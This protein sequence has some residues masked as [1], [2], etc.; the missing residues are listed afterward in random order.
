M[1]LAIGGKLESGKDTV[2]DYLVEK[3]K[4]V[5][6]A[7]ADN[8]KEM[9][10]HI[11]GL[12]EADCYTTEGKL[13]KFDEPI[14][15]DRI[16]NKYI[17]KEVIRWLS[18]VNNWKVTE[19]NVAKLIKLFEDVEGRKLYT[20][21]EVLQFFGTEVLRDC[22]DSDI[23]AKIVLKE[24]ARDEIEKA[25]IADARFENERKMVTAKGGKTVLIDC[26]Q[27]REQKSEH[28]SETG[29]GTKE[30]YDYYIVNDKEDGL[31]NLFMTVNQ[32]M[33]SLNE[34]TNRN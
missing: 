3:F 14:V 31:D 16:G 7:F 32:L 28:R 34:D 24:I 22:I 18:D 33:E 21:R 20:T 6:L 5:K 15:L 17:I 9:V 27:T 1:I 8:L 2:A 10:M 19:E 4:F 25:V 23:H 13:K 12:E 11:F 29:I 30:D 26:V